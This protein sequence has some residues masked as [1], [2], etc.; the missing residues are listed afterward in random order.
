MT[1]PK[2]A[3][4]ALYR[5]SLRESQKLF[6]PLVRYAFVNHIRNRFRRN[7]RIADEQLRYKK[8]KT[9][10]SRLEHLRAANAGTKQG[11][12]WAL[13]FAYGAS[14]PLRQ[15]SLKTFKDLSGP[16][17]QAKQARPPP[18]HPALHALLSA[19]QARTKPNSRTQPNGPAELSSLLEQRGWLGKLPER[20]EKNLWWRWWRAETTKI[21]VPAEIEVIEDKVGANPGLPAGRTPV[22]SSS[23]G[24]LD[25][26]GSGSTNSV[27]AAQRYGLPILKTQ[28]AGLGYLVEHFINNRAI[29]NPPRRSPGRTQESPVVV[30]TTAAS[31]TSPHNRFYR[32]RYRDVLNKMPFLSFKP[33]PVS[34]HTANSTSETQQPDM[35]ATPNAT[36]GKYSVRISPLAAT[37]GNPRNRVTYAVMSEEDRQWV[38][39]AQEAPGQ[40]KSKR[41]NA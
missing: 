20:R 5:A 22:L 18:F 17:D 19:Q 39:R 38:Q 13:R 33:A 4:L 29:P 14:G 27:A 34:S 41:K 16:H 23:P 2:S 32:R 40:V 7:I 10:K 24:I 15:Q 1:T 37:R 6:D 31:A 8:I 36:P 30:S 26:A 21:Q 35:Q 28:G 25:T 12:A 9:A 3:V 11:V